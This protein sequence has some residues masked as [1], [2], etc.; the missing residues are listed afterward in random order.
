ME[1]IKHRA[2]VE[3]GWQHVADG[4]PLPAG[5]DVTVS[6]ARWLAEHA[7]LA[8]RAASGGGRVGVRLAPSDDVAR[9]APHL[10]ALPLVAIEFPK[11][12]DGRGYTQARLVRER[13]GYAGEVRAIGYVLRDQ[14][15]YLHRCGFDAFE[16]H[17]GKSLTEALA[18]FDD[19]TVT[20]QPTGV[21]R[22]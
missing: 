21:P 19:F 20:Y 6:L 13:H 15:Y 11:F 18:A 5:V 4:Q 22:S 2:I 8:A 7:S 17:P 1:I 9:L 3:D 16:L 12:T 14:L 10:P